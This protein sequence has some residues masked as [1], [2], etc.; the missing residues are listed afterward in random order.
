[1]RSVLITGVMLPVSPKRL[2]C[3]YRDPEA[4]LATLQQNLMAI[5]DKRLHGTIMNV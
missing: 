3:L 4:A 1:L 2:A 5:I